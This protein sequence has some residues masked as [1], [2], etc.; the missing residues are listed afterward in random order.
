MSN[1]KLDANDQEKKSMITNK[2]H[3]FKV[4]TFEYTKVSLE[5]TIF[6]EVGNFII[7][8]LDFQDLKRI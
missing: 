4:I 5:L 2:I 1:P 6:N 8:W 7:S 3:M